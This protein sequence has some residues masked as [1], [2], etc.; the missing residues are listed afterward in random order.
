MLKKLRNK[1]DKIDLK[2]LK[3]LEERITLAEKMKTI[4]KGLMWK[5]EREEEVI[6]RL[7]S[8]T[9]KLQAQE[10]ITLWR[11]IIMTTLNHEEKLSINLYMENEQ[12]KTAIYNMIRKHFGFDIEITEEKKFPKTVNTQTL[13]ICEITDN[14]SQKPFWLQVEEKRIPLYINTHL[15]TEIRLAVFAKNKPNVNTLKEKTFVTNE[16]GVGKLISSYKN[17][18]LVSSVEILDNGFFIGF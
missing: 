12:N 14:P 5:P 13:Y 8:K 2:I 3:L 4:K 6:T 9:T 10:I 15:Q 16:L 1:I 11:S 18:Y 7:I 17:K